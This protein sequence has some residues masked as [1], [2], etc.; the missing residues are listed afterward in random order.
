M[1]ARPTSGFAAAHALQPVGHSSQ[2]GSGIHTRRV[3]PHRL[4]QAPNEDRHA[5]EIVTIEAPEFLEE[6]SVHVFRNA[7]CRASAG[8]VFR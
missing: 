4:E 6:L 7:T 3:V 2:L 8:A 1:R 5:P